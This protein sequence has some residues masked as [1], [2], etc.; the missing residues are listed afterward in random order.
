MKHL[1][2]IVWICLQDITLNG[3]EFNN[4]TLYPTKKSSK[5][6]MINLEHHS[7]DQVH[8]TPNQILNHFKPY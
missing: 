6:G 4:S 2:G 7:L 3:Y 8:L 1:E 5:K